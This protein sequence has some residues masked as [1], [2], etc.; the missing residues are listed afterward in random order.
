[1]WSGVHRVCPVQGTPGNVRR[2]GIARGDLVF[3]VVCL[4]VVAVGFPVL[5]TLARRVR[6]VS[7]RR[8]LGLGATALAVIVLGV[9]LLTLSNMDWSGLS[10]PRAVAT[11][12]WVTYVRDHL[13][14]GLG[15][16]RLYSA[17]GLMQPSY[18]G[19]YGFADLSFEDGVVPRDEATFAESDVEP[20]NDNA[21]A[22]IGNPMQGTVPNHLIG[23][24]LAGVTLLALPDP[25]C[26]PGC[27]G[28]SLRFDDRAAGVG[29]FSVPDPQPFLWFPTRVVKGNGVPAQ[30]L[31]VASVASA[32]S[33]PP[34]TA[35][36]SSPGHA[37]VR[38]GSDA[39]ASAR[40]VSADNSRLV[41]AVHAD[42]RR[43][44]VAREAAFPGWQATID[45]KRVAEV[46]VDGVFQG[47]MV[48]S[49]TSRVV[50]TY[51]PDG[52]SAAEA[53][54][55]AAVAW[56]VLSSA[57][58]FVRRRGVPRGRRAL[59]SEGPRGS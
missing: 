56:A 7:T 55:V 25:G 54:S 17:D 39:E 12:T 28:L 33:G 35:L 20:M 32:T 36:R 15:D 42:R 29:I 19:D 53:L 22:F 9:E 1:V 50:L 51:R 3:A 27:S 45:G 31:V 58:V 47:V 5:T 46:I 30:P 40:L 21:L 11:P 26:A 24:E 14:N 48:P 2:A 57:L 4:G 13:G 6:R 23:L 10:S 38:A 18:S 16:G 44:L 43:L 52:L 59:H 8:L 41:I 34:V 37:A 49:G